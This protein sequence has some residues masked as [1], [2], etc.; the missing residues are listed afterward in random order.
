[1]PAERSR[2][3]PVLVRRHWTDIFDP[4]PAATVL[5]LVLVVALPR[6]AIDSDPDSMIKAT[7][8]SAI[9]YPAVAGFGVPLCRAAWKALTGSDWSRP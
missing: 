3:H 7:I 8:I 4:R 9:V 1:M 5:A 2:R 6:V